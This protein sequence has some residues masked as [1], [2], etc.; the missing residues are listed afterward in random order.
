MHSDLLEES[1]RGQGVHTYLDK[2]KL[3]PEQLQ[4]VVGKA[5]T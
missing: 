5:I 1:V 3:K 4:E 2:K